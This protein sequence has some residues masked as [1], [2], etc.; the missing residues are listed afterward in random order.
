M[1]VEFHIFKYPGQGSKLTISKAV[2]PPQSRPLITLPGLPIS[3]LYSQS[4]IAL[5][6]L[7][8]VA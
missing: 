7:H 5:C 6:R 8:F 1:Q 4:V 3:S 2:S